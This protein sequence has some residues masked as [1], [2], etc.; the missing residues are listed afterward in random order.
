MHFDHGLTMDHG[1]H[2]ISLSFFPYGFIMKRLVNL[3][4][5]SLFSYARCLFVIAASKFM[6]LGNEELDLRLYFLHLPQ[7]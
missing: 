5:S 7:W 1:Q 2:Q 6:V 3:C 4:S